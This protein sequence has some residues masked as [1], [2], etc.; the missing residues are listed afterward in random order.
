MPRIP[1]GTKARVRVPGTSANLGPGFDSLGMALDWTDEIHVEVTESGFTADVV[2]EGAGE[3]PTDED[4]LVVSAVLRGLEDM[5]ASVPGLHVRAVNSVPHGRGLGSSA[6]AVVGGLLCAWQLVHRGLEPDRRRLGAMAVEYEGHADNA[7]A[8]MF[9]GLILTWGSHENYQHVMLRVNP[10]LRVMAF[11]PE[12]PVS[13]ARARSV[14]PDRVPRADAIDNASR[15]ALF[16][17][18]VQDDLGL[19]WQATSD[20]L[21]QDYRADLMPASYDLMKSLRSDGF[22]ATISGAGPS[23]L[24]LGSD[25][26]L[27][28]LSEVNFQGFRRHALHVGAA[29]RLF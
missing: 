14:L 5:D 13:T 28:R 24:V 23:V 11:V 3:I 29:A 6:G 19:L 8:C 10:R 20:K 21:H 27:D 18:A 16:V 15:A 17:H 12:T 22:A 4:N 1:I 2:G 26:Q 9:G 25:R 7:T